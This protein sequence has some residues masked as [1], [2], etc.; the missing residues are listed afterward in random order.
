MGGGGPGDIR[1]RGTEVHLLITVYHLTKPSA[2]PRVYLGEWREKGERKVGPGREGG[3]SIMCAHNYPSVWT[4]KE[5]F[6]APRRL[7]SPSH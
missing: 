7:F 1:K 4:A 3:G 5:L 2:C 6:S